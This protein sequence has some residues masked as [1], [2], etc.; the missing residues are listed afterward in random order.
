[1]AC[2][3][4]RMVHVLRVMH[5]ALRA[6]HA[7]AAESGAVEPRGKRHRR[8][9]KAV[10]V[11]HGERC[12]VAE[13]LRL[14]DCGASRFG[15]DAGRGELIIDAPSHVLGPGLAAVGPPGVL[16]RFLVEAAENVHV[17]E[18]VEHP[19]KPLALLWQEA[20]VL[21]VGA[22]VLEVDLLVR[23]IPVAA[24]YD[25]TAALREPVQLRNE[26]LHEAE[27]D[28]QAFRRAGTRGHVHRHDAEVAEL[29]LEVT[30]FGI[31]IGNAEALDHAI[32]FFAAIDA[33]TAVAGPIGAMKVAA[34]SVG[35]ADRVA[36]V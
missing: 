23:D 26:T 27:L 33:D 35:I 6:G 1:M 16:L 25:F 13:T 20:G 24:E 3:T 21:L 36:E 18:L 5:G 11:I 9:S 4:P 10:I 19:R 32:R 31:D 12:V 2:G 7:A 30:A 22:P 29:R 14:V 34:V 28:C 8:G 17:A 15:G